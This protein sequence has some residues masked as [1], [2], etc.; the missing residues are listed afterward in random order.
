MR[1]LAPNDTRDPCL[2]RHLVTVGSSHSP[3]QW[4]S[5]WSDKPC[6]Y[7]SWPPWTDQTPLAVH[8]HCWDGRLLVLVSV[9]LSLPTMSSLLLSWRQRRSRFWNEVASASLSES[10]TKRLSSLCSQ[11]HWRT[12]SIDQF[13]PVVWFGHFRCHRQ[14]VLFRHFRFCHDI[15]LSIHVRLHTVYGV[16]NSQCYASS[17]KRKQNV[18]LHCTYCTS[19]PHFLVRR[20][21]D[22]E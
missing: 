13:Q 14:T 18:L 21:L 11:P 3:L 15:V 8:K 12:Q 19:V 22:I 7:V 4:R 5:R 2:Q 6:S 17:D 20:F 9:C 16:Q 10:R 1:Q